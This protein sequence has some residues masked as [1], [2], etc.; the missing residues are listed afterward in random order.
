MTSTWCKWAVDSLN[1][2][3]VSA[4]PVLRFFSM[5]QKPTILDQRKYTLPGALRSV[6]MVSSGL[7]LS[8]IGVTSS[9]MYAEMCPPEAVC[10]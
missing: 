9:P 1:G 6:S 4:G 8:D 5:R 3:Y 10:P 7:P 2:G